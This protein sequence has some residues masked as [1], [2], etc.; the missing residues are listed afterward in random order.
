MERTFIGSD[1]EQWH[2]FGE[3]L[4]PAMRDRWSHYRYTFN[5]F[6]EVALKDKP[7]LSWGDVLSSLTQSTKDGKGHPITV[8]VDKEKK[9]CDALLRCYLAQDDIC[10]KYGPR[11]DA[12]PN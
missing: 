6:L 3:L 1:K 2:W 5:R 8:T 12:K 11:H 4:Y 9:D 7:T 10:A